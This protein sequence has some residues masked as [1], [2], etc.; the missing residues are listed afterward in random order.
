[1]AL[2]GFLFAQTA[3]EMDRILSTQEITYD[4]AARF[5]L[6]AANALPAG[7]NAFTIARERQWL[8]AKADSSISADKPISLG[9]LSLLI[10]K[11]FDLKGGIFYSIFPVPRYACREL[12]YLRIIQGRT[13]PGGRFDGGT[14]LQI[15]SR[16]LSYTEE[17][18]AS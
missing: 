1:M 10:M 16:V 3:D 4:Q 9:E 2:A 11:A 6:T 7:G 12:V 13:D 17:G 5:V 14:F 8:P 18:T 15:L